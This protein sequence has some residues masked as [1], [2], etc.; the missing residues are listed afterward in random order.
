MLLSTAI[1]IVDC[2]TQ[3]EMLDR[4]IRAVLGRDGLFVLEALAAPCA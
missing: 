2:I 3:R 4:C 1:C